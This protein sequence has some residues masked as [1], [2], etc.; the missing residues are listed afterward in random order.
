MLCQCR[1]IFADCHCH[2]R[3]KGN[4]DNAEIGHEFVQHVQHGQARGG[5][6]QRNGQQRHRYAHDDGRNH[7]S[8]VQ[9]VLHGGN[10]HFQNR[11][12]RSDAGK[13]QRTEK[14]HAQ[15][16]AHRRLVD[17]GREGDKRQT[18]AR[19]RHLAHFLAARLRHKA[20][21]GKH[22]D[23]GQ[24]LKAAVG[25][26]HHQAGAGQIGIAFQI[27]RIRYH[28]AEAD[29]Q[30]K[31]NL[32][33]GGN[34]HGRLTQFVPIWR[35]QRIQAF[36]SAWQKERADHQNTEHD[37]EQRHEKCRRFAHAFL[38]AQ[39]HDNQNK[40]PHAD[41]RQSHGRDEV[42]ADAGTIRHPQIFFE[43]EIGMIA[44][45]RFVEREIGVAGRPTQNHGIINTDDDVN[46]HLPPAECFQ[47]RTHAAER[48]WRRTT[49]FVPDG[50]IQKQQ[51]NA[52]RQQCHQIRNNKRAAA[53]IIRYI[54][55]TPNIAQAHC[56]ADGG[57]NKR[58]LPRESFPLWFRDRCLLI[59][60]NTHLCFDY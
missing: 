8:P 47:L 46:Q 36:S 27:R 33:V 16:A 15:Q 35:E 18:D 6:E 26:T 32:P 10:N 7:A 20:Q 11:N 21:C 54:R 19:C 42:H 30:R 45:P 1:Q 59:R 51:R 34:P 2:Q 58:F 31:E 17:N 57:K 52:R 22:A 38:H 56:R 5:A 9:L 41:L 40:R 29:G 60:H 48:Q 24:Q 14:Q 25:K 12:Q 4:G 37:G 53:V 49:V 44:A 13:Q 23:T 55:K 3:E 39:R 43:K 50:I 28:D